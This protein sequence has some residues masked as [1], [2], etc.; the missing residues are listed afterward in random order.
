[1]VM[2]DPHPIISTL[3]ATF[4]KAFF[5]FE[6]RRKPL[7]IGIHRDIAAALPALTAKEI[8]AGMRLYVGNQFYSR[9]CVEGAARIDLD[10]NAVGT[11]TV[12]EAASSAARL[13][14][15]KAWKKEKTAKK[16]ATKAAAKAAEIV[17]ARPTPKGVNAARPTLHLKGMT[18]P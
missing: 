12:G 18:S 9:S 1:M 17:A 6:R 16:A 7:K 10:G 14:G 2:I 4:P 3:C 15:I 5:M 8:G 11:V 13:A